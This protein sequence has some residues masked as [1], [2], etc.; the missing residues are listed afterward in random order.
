MLGLLDTNAWEQ[1]YNHTEMMPLWQ[2]QQ[3]WGGSQELIGD[4]SLSFQVAFLQKQSQGQAAC[5]SAPRLL[6]DSKASG[7][8][9]HPATSLLSQTEF[10][11]SNLSLFPILKGFS[12]LKEIYNLGDNP[13]DSTNSW[14][15]NYWV[16]ARKRLLELPQILIFF[17]NNFAKQ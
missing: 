8:S 6:R 7:P 5:P 14:R 3:T 16:R 10:Q 15:Q 12:W 4:T 11:V 13:R 2:Q 9:K 17:L 1:A